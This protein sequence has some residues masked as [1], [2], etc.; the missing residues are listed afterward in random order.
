MTPLF[1][2]YSFFYEYP[3]LYQSFHRSGD[4]SFGVPQEDN[5]SQKTYVEN[6]SH[7]SS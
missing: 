6:R 4:R 1:H 5:H 7:L 3:Q 2:E